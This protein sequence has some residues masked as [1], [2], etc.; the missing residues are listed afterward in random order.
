MIIKTSRNL[1][2]CGMHD[3]S[4]VDISTTGYK[5]YK[6]HFC[7]DGDDD[8]GNL[9]PFLFFSPIVGTISTVLVKKSLL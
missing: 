7:G 4:G 5:E 9:L 6:R 8:S 1:Y 2:R 3:P